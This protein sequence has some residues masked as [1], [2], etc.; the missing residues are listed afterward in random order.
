MERKW[1]N[2]C[3]NEP[4]L[5]EFI[6]SKDEI[7]EY[8]LLK[9]LSVREFILVL[10]V[11]AMRDNLHIEGEKMAFVETY[12]ENSDVVARFKAINPLL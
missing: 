12:T 3:D 1:I 6:F 9:G 2:N 8:E 10:R 11:E 7:L 4:R 5:Y